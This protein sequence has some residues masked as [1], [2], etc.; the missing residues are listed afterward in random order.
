[1]AVLIKDRD[2]GWFLWCVWYPLLSLFTL[3]RVLLFRT[4]D[5]AYVIVQEFFSTFGRYQIVN[6]A[7]QRR[8]TYRDRTRDFRRL[9]A[10]PVFPK[11]PRRTEALYWGAHEF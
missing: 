8:L 5:G 1:M 10:K 4:L 11:H 9:G 3:S 6:K 7:Q 2:H